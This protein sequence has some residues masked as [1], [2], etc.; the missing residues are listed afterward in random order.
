MLRGWATVAL[1]IATTA[2]ASACTAHASTPVSVGEVS[3]GSP[4]ASH[5]P[6][7]PTSSTSPHSTP[8]TAPTPADEDVARPPAAALA[9][10]GG[11]PI[12]G[13][14]GTYV[15]ADGGSDSPWLHGAPIAVGSGEPLNV[16]FLPPIEVVA[17]RA[18]SVPSSASDPS[19]ARSLGQGSGLPRFQGPGSGSWTVEVHAEFADGAGSAS[20]FWLVTAG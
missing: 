16:A 14:L 1:A 5:S 9:A 7:P 2:A 8:S 3:T 17:W 6:M 19:G 13:Q 11:D 18:R 20:Y 15:W 12:T 4:P 10:E